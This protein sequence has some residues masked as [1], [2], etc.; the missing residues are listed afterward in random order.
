MNSVYEPTLRTAKFS[1]VR[2]EPTVTYRHKV[3]RHFLQ[4]VKYQTT[5][6]NGHGDG[7]KVIVE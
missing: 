1:H 5:H 2:L 7:C 3:E 6:F 4:I